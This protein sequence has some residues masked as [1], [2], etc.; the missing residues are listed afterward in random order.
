MTEPTWVDEPDEFEEIEE[1]DDESTIEMGPDSLGGS[2]RLRS[3]DEAL[4]GGLPLLLL[5]REARYYKS[6]ADLV[7]QM[8]RTSAASLSLGMVVNLPRV[9]PPVAAT[10]LSSPCAASVRIA[11]PELYTR[12]DMWGPTLLEERDGPPRPDDPGKP[13]MPQRT[14]PLW[15]YW[16]RAL[17]SGP[18]A[19]WVA[20]VVDAQRQAGA[21]L[22]LTPGVPLDQHVPV[23]ALDQL[24]EHVAWARATLGDGERLA[25]T[26]PSR[27]RGWRPRPCALDCST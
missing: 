8:H 23:P 25:V 9:K 27:P 10:W 11:D 7:D 13:L 14:T 3:R 1:P 15:G 26:S 22:L 5:H 19:A 17:P 20:E 21:N 4:D 6:L 2:S 24:E 18:T 12:P 16:N